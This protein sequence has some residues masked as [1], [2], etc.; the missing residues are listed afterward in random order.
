MGKG[1]KRGSE[2]SCEDAEDHEAAIQTLDLN[3]GLP[4]TKVLLFSQY[5]VLQELAAPG[6]QL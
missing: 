5:G 1:E 3:S 4:T 6:E 2:R